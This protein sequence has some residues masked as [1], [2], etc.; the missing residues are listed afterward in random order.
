ME[1]TNTYKPDMI[2]GDYQVLLN[3]SELRCEG[4]IEAHNSP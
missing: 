1:L 4:E 3:S 2:A